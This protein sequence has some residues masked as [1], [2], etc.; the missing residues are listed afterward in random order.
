MNAASEKS[1][2]QVGGTDDDHYSASQ[3]RADRWS[4]LQD[5]S[6]RLCQ[7]SGEGKGTQRLHD[8]ATDLL[9]TLEP[10]EM[11]WAFPGRMVFERLKQLLYVKDYDELAKLVRRIVRA[12]SSGYY[13]RRTIP[14]VGETAEDD[15]SAD[16]EESPDA[17]AY[18][19][20]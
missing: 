2:S 6:Q 12:T 10:I 7:A 17:R 14:I 9:Q 20:P 4:G 18:A 1:A 15:Q 3:L 5:V 19:R 13:R 8:Q 16:E 11:F